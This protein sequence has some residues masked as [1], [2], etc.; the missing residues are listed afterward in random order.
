MKTFLVYSK[1]PQK[2]IKTLEDLS[3]VKFVKYG[4]NLL[5]FIDF[6]NVFYSLK[7]GFFVITT[8]LVVIYCII[9][10]DMF[11]QS[12]LVLA[13][14]I[15]AYSMEGWFLKKRGHRLIATI[16]AKNLKK[17]KEK[18]VNEYIYSK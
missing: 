12:V 7:R 2:L 5:Y 18:F 15:F 13:V 3:S 9:W 1:K 11:L 4:F 8:M 16:E 6:F 17:A 10:N 14:A